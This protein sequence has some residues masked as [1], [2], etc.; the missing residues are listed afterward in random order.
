MKYWDELYF[1]N[2]ISETVKFGKLNIKRY[3]QINNY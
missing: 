3:D 2:T 1:K